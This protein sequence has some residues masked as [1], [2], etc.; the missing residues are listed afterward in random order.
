MAA[1]VLVPLAVLMSQ[2]MDLVLPSNVPHDVT[3]V[4]VAWG[5]VFIQ[6]VSRAIH[7]ATGTF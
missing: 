6:R 5:D 1:D 7:V 3:Q 4:F 2:R